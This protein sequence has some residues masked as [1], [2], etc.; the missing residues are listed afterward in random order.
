MT[1]L[2]VLARRAAEFEAAGWRSLARW[3]SRRPDAGPGDAAFAYHGPLLAPIVVILVLSVIE[4]VA[5]DLIVPWPWQ[6]LRVVLLILG[7]WGAVLALGMLAGVIVHPHTAGP[8]GLRVR[9]GAGLDVRIP[10]D[11]VAGARRVRRSR[12]GRTVQVDGATLHVV[13]SNQ[14]TVEVTLNRPVTVALTGGR[15]AEITELR[16]HADDAAGLVAAVRARAEVI[17]GRAG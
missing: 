7:V 8:S 6:W 3:V 1:P 14:T 5:L 2:R 11:A 15:S 10:W 4:V 17:P 16:F 9:H 12:D 13:V